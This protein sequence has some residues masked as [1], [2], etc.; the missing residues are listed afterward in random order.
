MFATDNNQLEDGSND[1]D[2]GNEIDDQVS[3]DQ[4]AAQ[5]ISYSTGEITKES[6]GT[7][8][9]KPHFFQHL[10][11]SWFFL[12]HTTCFTTFYD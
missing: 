2:P 6:N 1:Q 4:A 10:L 11:L 5:S 3:S 7:S 8:S 9:G 12:H